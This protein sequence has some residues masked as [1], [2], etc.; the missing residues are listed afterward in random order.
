MVNTQ[1]KGIALVT[2]SARRIGRALAER[3]ARDGFDLALHVSP[4][5]RAEGAEV[6]AA[7]EAMG[8]RAEVLCADLMRDD[9]CRQLIDD[10]SRLGP[11]RV[12]INNASVFH[13]DSGAEFN[14][15]LWDQHF[16]LHA[17]APALLSSCFVQ[18]LGDEDDAVIINI[19]DQ[20]VL[21]PNPQFFS[22]TLSKMTLWAMT[23]TL[24]QSFAPH[25]RVNAVGPGPT[26]PNHMEGED[27]F[28]R[29]VAHV[30][31]QRAVDP[32]EIADAVS[33]LVSAQSVTGQILA[34]DGGQHI[35]WRTPDVDLES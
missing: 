16:A 6:K 34:V 19:V 10:A 25:V 20:R 9:Q 3:L 18:Q 22:Y 23:R 29:E 13:A 7:I 35:G 17:R 31:L 28:W 32:A 12:L 2:G 33:Y 4:R 27:G 30:P 8:R 14:A 15:D 5:S 21:R 1:A 11:L 24:A 26:L